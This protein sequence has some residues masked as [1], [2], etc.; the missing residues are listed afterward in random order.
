MRV[1]DETRFAALVQAGA[2]QQSQCEFL[3]GIKLGLHIERVGYMLP[4]VIDF[5]EECEEMRLIDLA[6]DVLLPGSLYLFRTVQ[7]ICLPPTV[8]GWL[9]TRSRFARLGLDFLGSST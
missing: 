2:I 4:D 9:H 7:A 8:F 6:H 1:V 5:D 3:D